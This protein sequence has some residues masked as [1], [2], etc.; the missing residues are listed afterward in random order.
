MFESLNRAPGL[1]APG[2]LPD[3]SGMQGDA[4][5]SRVLSTVDRLF[6]LLLSEEVRCTQ[7]G[8]D[9]TTHRL[10]PH[11]EYHVVVAAA[12]LR[13]TRMVLAMDMPGECGARRALHGM[14]VLVVKRNACLCMYAC[15]PKSHA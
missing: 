6:G 7:K 3:L 8:C 5:M 9:K 12:G 2:P 4:D 13:E 15:A 14:L 11:I 1:A 10:A